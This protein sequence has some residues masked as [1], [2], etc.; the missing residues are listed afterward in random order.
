MAENK[1]NEATQS[2]IQSLRESN[3]AVME[4]A[5]AAQ[6]RNVK[7]AQSVLEN[8]IEALK[9]HAE[10]TRALVQ[11]VSQKQPEAFQLIADSAVAAQERNIQFAQ[12]VLENGIE[13]LK[14]HAESTR[15]LTHTLLEQSQEQR[16]AFQTLVQESVEVYRK[17]LFA[18]LSY[19]EQAFEVTE[20]LTRQGVESFQKVTHQVME[21]AQKATA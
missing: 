14:S 19:F 21:N 20:T 7:F 6:E 2:L 9:S 15:S 13:V 17:L 10:S 12:G 18:P 3:Q 1:V 8:G 4:S 11:D 5:V 16:E